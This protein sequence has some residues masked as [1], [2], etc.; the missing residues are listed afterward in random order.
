MTYCSISRSSPLPSG[1]PTVMTSGLSR[2]VPVNFGVR[3]SKNASLPSRTSSVRSESRSS[4]GEFLG[5]LVNGVVG[6]LT[7]DALVDQPD[8]RSFPTGDRVTRRQHFL[9]ASETDEQWKERERRS[10]ASAGVSH[11]DQER[12]TPS[13]NLRQQTASRHPQ[14][15]QVGCRGQLIRGSRGRPRMRSPIWLR[16]ISDVPPAMERARVKIT[17]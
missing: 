4:V 3:F 5:E 9:R 15:T 8:L 2:H 16:V 14:L 1:R 17:A 10:R 11:V 12:A 6:L 13:T 7:G